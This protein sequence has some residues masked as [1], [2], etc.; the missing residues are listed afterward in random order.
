MTDVPAKFD[1]I[2][3]EPVR[4]FEYPKHQPP[5]PRSPYRVY[6]VWARSP[7]GPVH[8]GVPMLIQY[9]RE[10]RG[11]VHDQLYRPQWGDYFVITHWSKQP[12]GPTDFNVTMREREDAEDEGRPWPPPTPMYRLEDP[13][14]G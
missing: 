10:T 2:E 7:T 14:H 1:Y 6:L 5:V 8:G 9:S 13:S 12:I 11:F 3:R 4:W